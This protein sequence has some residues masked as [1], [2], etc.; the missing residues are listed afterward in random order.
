MQLMEL[1]DK[2]K[3]KEKHANSLP[4]RDNDNDAVEPKARKLGKKVSD[5]SA[6][7]QGLLTKEAKDSDH[8]PLTKGQGTCKPLEAPS[9]LRRRAGQKVT[10]RPEG[11]SKPLKAQLGLSNK[12]VKTKKP[13]KTK[14]SSLTKG[15][16][17]T[18]SQKTKGKQMGK[19]AQQPSL[20]HQV[21]ERECH[22]LGWL[23]QTPK[24]HLGGAT[25]VAL[26]P[27]VGKE[28]CL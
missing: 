6:A 4:P 20:S 25:F 9:F 26:L 27:Q 10:A 23:S 3:K 18:G 2:I 28:S 5:V 1:L 14:N 15:A 21:R 11:T 22:G 8:L 17:K 24:S 16:T 13:N 19:A 12:N 7:C